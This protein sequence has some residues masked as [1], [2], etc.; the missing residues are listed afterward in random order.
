VIFGISWPW[1]R[2]ILIRGLYWSTRSWN[3]YRHGSASNGSET[4]RL[5]SQVPQSYGTESAQPDNETRRQSSTWWKQFRKPDLTRADLM[6]AGII[7]LA[8]I[9]YAV[10]GGAV[11]EIPANTLGRT[12]TLKS[13]C[14]PWDLKP[15]F[16]RRVRD[17]DKK[18]RA[19]K[20]VR[21]AN[22]GR[23]CYGSHSVYTPGRCDFFEASQIEYTVE[24][25][26]CP[27]D[28]TKDRCICARGRF[29]TA[30]RLSTGSFSAEKLGLNGK[31]LPFIRRT[32]TFVPLDI[33]YGF[34]VEVGKWV[35]EYYLGP[36]NGRNYTFDTWGDP[37]NWDIAAYSVR[38]YM[39][40]LPQT[41]MRILLKCVLQCVRINT[42]SSTRRLASNRRA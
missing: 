7:A 41:P 3:Y 36:V 40:A 20:E 5:L 15:D 34:V 39:P 26:H 30:R 28:C 31:N 33:D 18:Y 42:I 35:Y 38:Y 8:A 9:S 27:F 22:Y 29:E 21:A 37:F 1:A 6:L 17:Y 10:A 12:N 25:I 11:G 14:G 32:S 16:D 2:A 13:A 19:G 24:P 4:R 23:D